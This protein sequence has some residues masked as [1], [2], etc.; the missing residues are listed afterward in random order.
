MYELQVCVKV[1]TDAT[2]NFGFLGNDTMQS[3][4]HG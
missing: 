1:C 4:L 3:V 2:L